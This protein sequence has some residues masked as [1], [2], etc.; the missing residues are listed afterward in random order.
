MSRIALV[1]VTVAV[2][3]TAL[4]NFG[5]VKVSDFA[6]TWESVVVGHQWWRPF[7]AVF[8]CGPLRWATAVTIYYG[9]YHL[10][11]IESTMFAQMPVDFLIFLV[12][13][14]GAAT[15]AAL[16]EDNP[17]LYMYFEMYL[18]YYIIRQVFAIRDFPPF[19]RVCVLAQMAYGVYTCLTKGLI[20]LL[21]VIL[22][23]HAYFFLGDCCRVRYDVALLRAPKVANNLLN[24]ILDVFV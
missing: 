7:A 9:Y 2:F 21:L 5:I 14:V 22:A 23:S 20:G 12:I 13:G 8:Y 1:F 15:G 19:L 18:A 10:E 11:C 3:L 24:R 6:V 16:K 4:V 17:F